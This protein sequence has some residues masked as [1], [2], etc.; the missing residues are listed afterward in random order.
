[1]NTIR[2]ILNKI[3]LISKT[4]NPSRSDSKFPVFIF[5]LLNILSWDVFG[6]FKRSFEGRTINFFLKFI[7]VL[8]V[9]NILSK[10]DPSFIIFSSTSIRLMKLGSEIYMYFDHAYLFV[11]NFSR[12]SY[13]IKLDFKTINGM[14]EK[15]RKVNE[16]INRI[17]PNIQICRTPWA[18][19]TCFWK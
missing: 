5:W 3:F 17:F 16:Y 8:I 18:T 10:N 1:M 6:F 9:L 11:I 2:I 7:N 12:S 13:L 4:S 19:F 14:R 15:R